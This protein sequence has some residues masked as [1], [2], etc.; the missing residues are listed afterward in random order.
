VAALAGALVTAVTGAHVLVVTLFGRKDAALGGLAGV[1]GAGVAVI[2]NQGGGLA[3]QNLVALVDG[4][5]VGIVTFNALEPAATLGVAR[6]LCAGVAVVTGDVLVQ[7]L[8]G[9]G[10][11]GVHGAFVVIRAGLGG[12]GDQAGDGVTLVNG[13]GVAIVTVDVPVDAAL[14]LV[15]L[16]NLALDGGAQVVL[17]HGLAGAGNA[18][19][20]GARDLVVANLGLGDPSLLPVTVLHFAGATLGTPP[21]H[22]LLVAHTSLGVAPGTSAS[23]LGLAGL[24][25]VLAALGSASVGGAGVLIVANLVHAGVDAFASTAGVNGA[26]HSIVAV[27][28]GARVGALD[29]VLLKGTGLQGHVTG[30]LHARVVRHAKLVGGLVGN[31]ASLGVTPVNG[32]LALVIDE[33]FL[34]EAKVQ[35]ALYK[36]AL[37]RA[38]AAGVTTVHHAGVVAH[39]G[40]T[41]AVHVVNLVD[42][43]AGG[44]ITV[45]LGAGGAVGALLER[46]L[47]AHLGVTGV[48]SAQVVVGTGDGGIGAALGGVAHV[49]GAPVV[50]VARS[51]GA[52]GSRGRLGLGGASLL[53]VLDTAQNGGNIKVLTTVLHGTAVALGAECIDPGGTAT[54][55]STGVGSSA[56]QRSSGQALGLQLV[57]GE[58]LVAS[59]EPLVDQPH[60]EVHGTS[61]ISAHNGNALGTSVVITVTVS[62]GMV[63]TAHGLGRGVATT[64]NGT[65]HLPGA[66]VHGLGASLELLVGVGAAPGVG[67]VLAHNVDALGTAHGARAVSIGMVDPADSLS[68]SDARTT[69]LNGD[70]VSALV[71]RLGFGASLDPLLGKGNTPGHTAASIGTGHG[72]TVGPGHGA[73]TMSVGVVHAAQS[74][75]GGVA[76]TALLDSHGV[77]A[78]VDRNGFGA[79]LDLLSSQGNAPSHAASSVGTGHGNTLGTGNS[80]RAMSVRVSHTAQSLPGGVATTALL[81]GNPVVAH[82][83]GRLNTSLNPLSGKGNTPSHTASSISTSHGNPGSLG[84]GARAVGVRVSHAAQGLGRGVSTTASLDGSSV[85]TL[86][87]GH[88]LLQPLVAQVG[89]E[90]NGT[91]SISANHGNSGGP[92]H[93]AATVGVGMVNP[94]NSLC[95]GVST[96]A[97]LNGMVVRAPVA[98]GLSVKQVEA[99]QTANHALGGLFVGVRRAQDTTNF[100][101]LSLAGATSISHGSN[102]QEGN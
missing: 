83:G 61:G 48:F 35:G 26:L 42:A 18:H 11:A 76:T 31:L 24:G 60:A 79:S 97:S 5:Q 102:R 30:A 77:R 81:H 50:V 21:A 27:H 75:P 59:L 72:N 14:L 69:N 51:R 7:A 84:D 23:I 78:Q 71:D 8:A 44:S 54:S 58:G 22:V 64:A 6:V 43:L 36:V 95:R 82:V 12:M 19:V 33:V 56:E 34:A 74:L 99:K 91:S 10:L 47:A 101:L 65:G 49:L 53:H 92:G 4:A 90:S 28:V 15:A 63:Q 3:A 66:L 41:G 70:S 17:G 39:L 55:G 68:G 100:A 87:G 52:L 88:T 94:A 98:S 37:G 29:L 46:V 57:F 62:I 80:A 73:S 67:S 25:H 2:A 32:A 13:A 89:A 96:T 85:R 93:V 9:V 38:A 86:V 16:G 40:G 20:L 45:V 1:N